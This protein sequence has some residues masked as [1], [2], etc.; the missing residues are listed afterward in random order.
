MECLSSYLQFNFPQWNIVIVYKSCISFV[1]LIPKHFI[2]VDTIR[3][4]GG[5][6]V[7][8]VAFRISIPW[9]GI[10]P[11]PP[12]VE[13]QSPLNCQ[14]ISWNYTLNFI[15]GLLLFAMWN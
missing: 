13:V 3:D 4:F 2:L 1:K 14:G 8:H 5:M 6:C 12:A 15:F 11:V 10:K 7:S 9:L